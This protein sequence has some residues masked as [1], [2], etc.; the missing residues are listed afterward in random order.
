MRGFLLGCH[1][2]PDASSLDFS[3]RDAPVEHR[4]GRRRI[5]LPIRDL[6]RPP[7]STVR[8]WD[9]TVADLKTKA[10]ASNHFVFYKGIL[11]RQTIAKVSTIMAGSP[12][13]QSFW[14]HDG[15]L[16]AGC[17]PGDLDPAMRDSKLRGLI[18]CG[19]RRVVTLMEKAT[20]GVRSSLTCNVYTK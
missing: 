10:T 1:S 9:E 16:C 7:A 6:H 17:Y 15:L 2:I 12:F 4:P 8:S 20:V 3:L 13:P 14:V 18:A 5:C 19:I 11:C